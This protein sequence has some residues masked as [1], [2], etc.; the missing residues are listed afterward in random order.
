[1]ANVGSVTVGLALESAAF[2]RD[3]GKAAG[4]PVLLTKEE[5]RERQKRRIN[6]LRH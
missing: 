4:A 6:L 1:M 2:K 3:M 5:K